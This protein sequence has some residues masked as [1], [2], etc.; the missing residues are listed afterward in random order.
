MATL[1]QKRA[2]IYKDFDLSFGVNSITGDIN[3]KLDVNAV[4]QAMKSLILTQRFERPFQ[5]FLSTELAGLLFENP[6]MFTA[7]K[8][9]VT[10]LNVLDNYEKRAKVSS[11]EVYPYLDENRYDVKIFFEVVGINQPEEL[12]IKLERLR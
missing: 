1:R 2:R 4:K 11:V 10:I 5:P 12:Q 6:S 7:D 3:K 8:I 9:R